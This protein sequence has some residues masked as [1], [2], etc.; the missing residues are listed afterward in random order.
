MK[1][2]VYIREAAQTDILKTSDWYEDQRDGLGD[3]FLVCLADALSRLEADPEQ[4][5]SY[6][7]GFRRV[8][9][10]RFPYRLFFRIEQDAVI[11][12]RILHVARNHARQLK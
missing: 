8:L 9:T 6:H 5:P 11:V 4:F 3:E 7:R 2:R 10:E 1:W 12:F